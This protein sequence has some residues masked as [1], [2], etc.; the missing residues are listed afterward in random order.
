MNRTINNRNQHD[1][2]DD[3]LRKL[4]ISNVMC[5]TVFYSKPVLAQTRHAGAEVIAH[6]Q[7]NCGDHSVE[8]W[9]SERVLHSD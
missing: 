6:A 1:A 8:I 5:N 3:S 7:G 4:Y 2:E 9:R